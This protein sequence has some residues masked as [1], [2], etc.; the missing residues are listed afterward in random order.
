MELDDIYSGVSS[1]ILRLVHK[2]QVYIVKKSTVHYYT[3][4]SRLS[5]SCP[6]ILLFTQIYPNVERHLN[7]RKNNNKK[8]PLIIYCIFMFTLKWLERGISLISIYIYREKK[9]RRCFGPPITE[10]LQI[11]RICFWRGEVSC[12]YVS[13]ICLQIKHCSLLHTLSILILKR[14]LTD[15]SS[16]AIFTK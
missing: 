2:L 3:G 11:I 7:I 16:T 5:R 14:G 12:Q 15:P 10:T 4:G 13:S 8:D 6:I 9:K 1:N